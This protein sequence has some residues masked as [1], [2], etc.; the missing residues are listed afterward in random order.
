MSEKKRNVN[1]VFA[2][3]VV[4]LTGAAVTAMYES[5]NQPVILEAPAVSAGEAQL[6][7]GHPP[8]DTSSQAAAL[9]KA[10]QSDP[11]NAELRTQLGNTYYDARRFDKA[12]D[13]Y[14]ESLRLKPGDPSVE[15]DLATSYHNTGQH[16]RALETLDN[17][18][19]H[20][21]GFAQALFNKGVVL[22]AGKNDAAGAAAAWEEL[23]RRNPDFPQKA[24]LEARIRQ[25]RAGR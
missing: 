21:P 12:I 7:E 6:P 10:I 3:V 16:D 19:R 24:E 14:T 4:L 9:E 1:M 22:Q 25:L 13:A 20:S 11:N 8:L 17:V 15:T 23:L 18:L 5:R 2:T